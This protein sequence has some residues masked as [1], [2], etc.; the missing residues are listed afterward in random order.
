MQALL[1]LLVCWGFSLQCE[2][3]NSLSVSS[4][5]A[6]WVHFSTFPCFTQHETIPSAQKTPF[7]GLYTRFCGT[8]WKLEGCSNFSVGRLGHVH[9]DERSPP[10]N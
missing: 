3:E 9:S 10:G 6:G 4:F 7:M 2:S 8:Q 1:L 5:R